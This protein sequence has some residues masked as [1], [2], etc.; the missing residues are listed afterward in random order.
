MFLLERG[1]FMA[2]K[3]STCIT[4]LIQIL[5]IHINLDSLSDTSS[6]DS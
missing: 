1:K 5:G 3:F 4:D 2:P 6:M